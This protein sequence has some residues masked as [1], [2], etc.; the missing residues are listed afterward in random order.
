MRWFLLCIIFFFHLNKYSQNI[1]GI[2]NFILASQQDQEIL[3]QEYFKPLFSS[4]QTSMSEGWVKTAKPHKK[5]GFDFTF[6]MSG[7]NIPV[8]D[9]QFNTQV[10]NNITST[11]TESPTIFGSNSNESYLIEFYPPDSDYSMSTSFGVPNGHEDLLTNERLLLPNFQFSIGVP[12]KSELILRYMPETT[13]KGASFRSMGVGLKHSLS[14]YFKPAKVTPINV[15]ILANSSKM[16]SVY[17]FGVNS[18][19]VGE[20]QSINLVVVNSSV[21]LVASADLKL[22]TVYASIM[23]VISKSSL[24]VTGSYELNYETSSAEIGEVSFVVEDPISIVS[25]LNYQRKNIGLAFNFAFYNL[26][27]DYSFQNYNSINIGLSLGLR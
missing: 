4:L 24:N 14:Q 25:N 27:V 1:G 18:Q 11:S 13:H 2:E 10:F 8:Y 21:G 6:I 20:N 12:F 15:S 16:E 5:L 17:N 26:F 23:Q 22:L 7:I 19:I 9:R 3:I